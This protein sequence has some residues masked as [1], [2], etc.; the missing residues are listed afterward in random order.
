MC[1]TS[2]KCPGTID[3]YPEGQYRSLQDITV[4]SHN[5]ATLRPI[6]LDGQNEDSALLS[7]LRFF[8]LND[9]LR[10]ELKIA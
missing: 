10:P 6:Q 9:A 7:H 3:E 2:F 4:V 5:C 1:V 8:Q